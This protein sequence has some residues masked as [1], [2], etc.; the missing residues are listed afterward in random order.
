[1][2]SSSSTCT[3]GDPALGL[4]GINNGSFAV[5]TN[6]Q[7]L[8][9]SKCTTIDYLILEGCPDC[10]Q[11]AWCGLHLE[12]ITGKD[13]LYERSVYLYNAPAITDM[14]GI[15]RVTGPLK[16]GF[17]VYTM[18]GFI[19]IDGAEGITSVGLS[20]GGSIDLNN[21]PFLAS[22]AALSDVEYPANSLR[23]KDCTRLGCVPPAWPATDSLG[24]SIPSGSLNFCA[25]SARE[26]RCP[27]GQRLSLNPFDSTGD[28]G[29]CDCDRYCASN[30]ANH[31][32]TSRSDWKGAIC[33]SAQT[34]SGTPIACSA[35]SSEG[36]NCYCIEASHFC[37]PAWPALDGVDDK[38]CRN[39]CPTEL[40]P[41]VCVPI[42]SYRSGSAVA[43]GAIV[44]GIIA[45]LA[46]AACLAFLLFR[47][48]RA[49]HASK[50]VDGGDTNAHE[51]TETKKTAVPN[52]LHTS[53]SV[54]DTSAAHDVAH[55]AAQV[56]EGVL[57]VD[58]TPQFDIDNGFPINDSA[59]ALCVRRW[60]SHRDLNA[61]YNTGDS[62]NCTTIVSYADLQAATSDFSG[63]NKIGDGGSCSVYKGELYGVPCAIKILS[64]EASAW[65][66]TQFTHEIDVLSRVKHSNICQV[67]I[68]VAYTGTTSP[69]LPTR[70]PSRP[71]L[72]TP[73]LS[74]SASSM[75]ALP[76]ARA[77]A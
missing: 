66:E 28:D 52:V 23:V 39:A 73:P 54:L 33:I 19:S 13:P 47:K 70:I 18:D 65:E 29:S 45:A 68:L 17:C 51:L 40:P 7:L 25:T 30:W 34:V 20:K 60:T 31:V 12:S 57:A 22:A 2:G 53:A 11:D 5:T 16:G 14:C 48:R 41:P 8:A 69:L 38:M 63:S 15:K 27:A 35:G 76:T 36:I 64:R 1:M 3:A 58:D 21:N 44:G 49:N 42:P 74:F 61:S 75:R 32:K 59:R 9:L 24:V 55:T 43:V 72:L 26:A 50:G 77:V 62:S 4:T 56:G 6:A 71:L 67:Y 37:D 10:T 46:V